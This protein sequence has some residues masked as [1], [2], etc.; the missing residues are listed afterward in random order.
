MRTED[1]A[2]A[3]RDPEPRLRDQNIAM[4]DSGHSLPENDGPNVVGSASKPGMSVQH[5]KFIMQS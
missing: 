1:A 2:I 5:L 3:L 4:R